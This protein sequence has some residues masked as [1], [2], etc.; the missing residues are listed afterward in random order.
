MWPLSTLE[1][2]TAG[3]EGSFPGGSHTLQI[4][5]GEWRASD[6]VSITQRIVV[7]MV[8]V[9]YHLSLG[10]KNVITLLL[11]PPPPHWLSIF[12]VVI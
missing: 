4:F 5:S 2:G 7:S 10:F 9:L 8:K 12:I 11:P 1:I 6:G 3:P